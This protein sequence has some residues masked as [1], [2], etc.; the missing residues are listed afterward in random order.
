MANLSDRLNRA[1]LGGFVGRTA[2]IELFRNAVTAV[3][4]P[5][6]ALHVHG[7]GGVGKSTLLRE[8]AR[9]AAEHGVRPLLLDG[10]ALE[11]TAE[12]L[13]SA[14]ASVL[15]QQEGGEPD[16][17]R[18][19]FERLRHGGRRYV[20]MLDTCE[21]LLAIDPWIR[22]EFLPQLPDSTLV[23]M[24]SRLRPQPPW[25]SDAGWQSLLR[26]LPLRNLSP[27]ESRSY[28]TRRQIP[29]DQHDAV[30][31]FSHGHPL[32]LSLIADAFTH[33]AESV[34]RP[35]EAPDLVKSLLERFVAN[36]PGPE[37]RAALEA[38]ALVRITTEPLLGELLARPDAR[39]IFEWLRGLSFIESN[40]DGLFPHALA[41]EAIT[42][43]LKWRNPER[44]VELHRRARDYYGRRLQ[45]TSGREQRHVLYE[46]VYLH[47]ENP[48]V[49]PVFEWQNDSGLR[50]DP[51]SP[52]D[53]QPLGEMVARFEGPSSR[54][55]FEHWFSQQPGRFL[56][57]RDSTAT[58]AGFLATLR[59]D[60]ASPAAIKQ[61]PATQLAADHL[62]KSAP[63]RAGETATY[64][65]F[66]MSR[67]HY[68]GISPVQ[69]LLIVQVV[70]HYLTTP[71]LAFHFV[72]VTQPEFWAPAFTYAD[73]HRLDS[74]DFELDGRRFGVFGHDWRRVPLLAWL[75]LLAEREMG[76]ATS[77][78]SLPE[79]KETL[80][81]L[82]RD[83]FDTALRECVKSWTKPDAIRDSPLLRTRIV[84][85]R[86]GLEAG[87]KA[88]VL[89]LREQIKEIAAGMKNSP[90]DLKLLRAVHYTYFQPL[91]TQEMVAAR[92]SLPFSTYRR[93]L[94]SGI[95]RI[96]DL[97][98][99]REVG[100]L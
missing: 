83:E 37:H 85:E 46:Y 44:Y 66:C 32:A 86:A 39:E 60:E 93:H 42:A 81:V 94:A 25:R 23:V 61:D 34:F 98:W 53:A 55:L 5:F 71:N 27:D 4:P 78:A 68:Q 22:E 47:R 89:A 95:G 18:S 51:A 8:F 3:D 30:V 10:S 6:A 99:A 28:L 12:A 2:E 43:D 36:L 82:S 14:L 90:R 7:P 35:E 54:A 19:V 21:N 74:L 31:Q 52:A 45:E 73:M 16:E 40:R 91:E 75:A 70:Q 48:I 58:P 96:A 11:P 62:A 1:R 97:L 76:A 77:A 38:S 57:V 67:D 26:V 79:A 9:L 29:A 63:L 88:R 65:R 100:E 41:R 49:R 92:L 17:A 20:L 80:L 64:I 87:T 69:S 24:A 59:L 13:Q 56:V 72:P 50:M 84:V 33:R 15:A